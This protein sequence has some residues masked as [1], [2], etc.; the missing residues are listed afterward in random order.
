MLRLIRQ[1]GAVRQEE[2]RSGWCDFETNAG[3]TAWRQESIA[4]ADGGARMNRPARPIEGIV[5]EVEGALVREGLFVPQGY[6]PLVGNRGPF[7]PISKERHIVGFAH[8]EI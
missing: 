3:E 4:V 8:I 7:V 6:L 1:H 5:N 2:S